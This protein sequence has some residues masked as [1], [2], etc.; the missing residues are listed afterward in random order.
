[1]T[2]DLRL[3]SDCLTVSYHLQTWWSI[4][5]SLIIVVITCLSLLFRRERNAWYIGITTKWK[6]IISRSE[7]AVKQCTLGR[8][9]G[10]I[11]FYLKKKLSFFVV[12]SEKRIKKF[13]VFMKI[14][15]RKRFPFTYSIKISASKCRKP[16]TKFCLSVCFWRTVQT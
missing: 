1:M 15:S 12:L 3:K 5:G 10:H 14:N 16:L 6:N 4:N 8:V 9:G 2:V 7:I 13:G 11:P